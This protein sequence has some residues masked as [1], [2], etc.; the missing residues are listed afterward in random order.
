[1]PLDVPRYAPEA[2]AESIQ[3]PFASG[4]VS[5]PLDVVLLIL[6]T[7]GNLE[8]SSDAR[9][10][11][12]ICAR[13][14]QSMLR[15]SRVR[16]Y[17]TVVLSRRQQFKNF[18]R[19]LIW[20]P[21]LALMVKTLHTTFVP[22]DLD[23]SRLLA[24][25]LPLS[26][27]AI[28]S[29]TNLQELVICGLRETILRDVD[30]PRDFSV[31]EAF[32][33][34]FAASC[35]KLTCLRLRTVQFGEHAGFVRCI[36]AFPALETLELEG[37][38]W[39]NIGRLTK[40]DIQKALP[41]KIRI[42]NIL[43]HEHRTPYWDFT[44]LYWGAAVQS[45]VLRVAHW[46]GI[47]KS[48]LTGLSALPH[49]AHI[50]LHFTDFDISGA[51][52]VLSSITSTSM[53]TVRVVHYCQMNHDMPQLYAILKLDEILDGPAFK[54]LTMVTWCFVSNFGQAQVWLAG[55]PRCFPRLTRRKILVGRWR[56]ER[57]PRRWLEECT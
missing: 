10:T 5:L 53:R 21:E 29:M 56:F 2:M 26:S 55:L 11:L 17:A 34:S 25:E 37:V 4:V 14:C 57:S 27:H 42:L 52:Y 31:L 16:L 7:V 24:N 20:N 30:E 41:A 3:S 13:S 51:A 22:A 19:T 18:G 1:M 45:L 12:C 15:P 28:R 36:A 6:D 35:P 9:K 8:P 50:D 54:S 48:E 46:Q 39:M 38:R 23:A 32:F 40:V 44:K 47:H 49:L 43:L 33:E